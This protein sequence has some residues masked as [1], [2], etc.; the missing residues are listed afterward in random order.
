MVA[1]RPEWISHRCG[2]D[3]DGATGKRCGL[4]GR[5]PAHGRGEV[6]AVVLNAIG[7]PMA[8]EEIPTPEPRAGEVLIRVEACGVCH[9]DLHVIKA[10]V[11]FPTPCVLGHEVSGTVVAHGPGLSAID[12]ERL[13]VGRRV[14]RRVHHA[15][16]DL[17]LLR[18]RPGRAVRD[19]LH[20]QPPPGQ[21]VRR[22]HAPAFGRT[23]R[24]S[25][26][27]RWAAWPSTPSSP[28]PAWR[29]CRTTCRSRRR[30]SSGAPSSRRTARS[31]VARTSGP[32]SRSRSSRRAASART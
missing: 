8:V 21:A 5:Y 15:V 19:V 23:A 13:A 31:D 2:A 9:T 26:C 12:A 24:R 3:T 29:R 32:A 14:G 22:R 28:S 16:R 18:A 7:A 6:K 30:R 4:S 20:R 10:E 1:T 17:L 27:T 25:G 11:R